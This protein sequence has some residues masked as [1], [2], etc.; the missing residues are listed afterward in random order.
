MVAA[1]RLAQN[2]MVISRWDMPFANS[3]FAVSPLLFSG[4]SGDSLSRMDG[5]RCGVFSRR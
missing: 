1:L 4:S 3:L 2:V 5:D